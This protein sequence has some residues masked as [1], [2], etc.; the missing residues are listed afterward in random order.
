MTVCCLIK[1]FLTFGFMTDWIVH[2]NKEKLFHHSLLIHVQV[3]VS[4]SSFN[5]GDIFLLDM[6]KAIVQWNGPKS[7]R[8]EKLKVILH[9]L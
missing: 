1:V 4:W 3:E 8:R 5:N 9:S 7:N 6:G 2:L